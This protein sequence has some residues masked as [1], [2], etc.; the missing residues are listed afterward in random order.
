MLHQALQGHAAGWDKHR[1]LPRPVTAI[2]MGLVA[3]RRVT[4]LG[5]QLTSY[6]VII[7]TMAAF[8]EGEARQMTTASQ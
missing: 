4:L 6:L 3:L 7:L 5:M 8:W 1:S 2:S